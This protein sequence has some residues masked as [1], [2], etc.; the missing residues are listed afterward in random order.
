MLNITVRNV[1]AHR[2]KTIGAIDPLGLVRDQ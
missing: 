1:I 2:I